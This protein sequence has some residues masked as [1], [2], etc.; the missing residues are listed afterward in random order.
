MLEFVRIREP[1]VFKLIPRYLFE[2]IKDREYN[3]EQIYKFGPILIL[4]RFNCVYLMVNDENLIKGILIITFDPLAEMILVYV[5]SIDKEYQNKGILSQT[6]D[7]LKHIKEKDP[8]FKIMLDD[9]GFNLK[10]K[11]IWQTTRP[12]SYEKKI[13]AKRSK[14]TIMET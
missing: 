10:E 8:D 9:L 11:I 4:S 12:R 7:F 14:Y 1:Q 5:L 2:Q 6:K 3:I 13:G